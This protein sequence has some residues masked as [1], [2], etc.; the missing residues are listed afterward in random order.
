MGKYM[1]PVSGIGLNCA[2]EF[3]EFLGNTSV[4]C[5]C[6]HFYPPFL[7]AFFCR[8]ENKFFAF[9]LELFQTGLIIDEAERFNLRFGWEATV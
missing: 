5:P 2:L 6:H 9:I 8:F 3:S 1:V 4:K 7:K